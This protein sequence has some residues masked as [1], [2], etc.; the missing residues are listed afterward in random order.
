MSFVKGR[1][2]SAETI[3]TQLVP[4][5]YP[6]PCQTSKTE[7]CENNSQQEKLAKIVHS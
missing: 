2:L 7:F 6:D 1:Y 4:E 5:L 3:K